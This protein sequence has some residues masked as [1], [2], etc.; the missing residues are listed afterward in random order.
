M[1]LTNFIKILY[2]RY[3]N[4]IRRV[5]KKVGGLEKN[6]KQ[7]NITVVLKIDNKKKGYVNVIYY[8]YNRNI[9]TLKLSCDEQHRF[10][11]KI[12]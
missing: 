5:K 8:C 9:I 7:K 10:T 12:S 2:E 6:F 11:L 3:K 1:K 4:R